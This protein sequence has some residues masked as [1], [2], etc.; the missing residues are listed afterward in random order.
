MRETTRKFKTVNDR[1]HG[2][3]DDATGELDECE[4]NAGLW[5]TVVVTSVP[6]PSSNTALPLERGWGLEM[7]SIVMAGNGL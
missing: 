6:R 5:L 7:G 1:N 3:R 2:A 4:V